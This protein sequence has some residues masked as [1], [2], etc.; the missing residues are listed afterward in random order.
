[1]ARLRLRSWRLLLLWIG[2]GLAFWVGSPSH[3]EGQNGKA[4]RWQVTQK[5][6]IHW[7]V[8]P[9]GKLFYSKGVNF[10]DPGKD[11]PRSQKKH[12]YY[13][14]NFFPSIDEWRRQTTVQLQGWGFNTRGGWSDDSPN[15][16]LPLMVDIELGRNSKFHWFDSFHPTMEERVME[17]AEKLTAPYRHDHR[18]VGYFSDNE[19][20]WW[21]SALF[22][23]YL[24]K[25]WDNY[26]KRVLW[27][28]LYDQYTGEWDRL[29]A[30]WVVPEDVRG[31][32]DLKRADVE[33]KLRPGGSGIRVVD[34]FMFLVAQHYYDL[35]YRSIRKA[36]PEA[37]VLGD[38]L[39]LYYHQDAV[40]AIGD[41]VDVISTNYNV[42]GPDGWVAPYY[43]EGL[44]RLSHKPVIVTE[45]FFAAEENRTGN[46][47]ETARSK[48]P[49][50]GHLMTVQ[51]QEERARGISNTVRRFARFPN[52]VGA[53]WFQYCDEPF[54]GREQDGED[55]NMGL[56]DTSNGAYEEVTA[57]FRLA[58][59]EI[60]S[61]HSEA[62]RV[63][64]RE[65]P[66]FFSPSPAEAAVDG[67]LVVLRASNPPS[68]SDQSLL[69][70]DKDK[71]R[72]P[73]VQAPEPYV[74]F[75]DLHLSW[76][77]EG[78]Y[79]ATI[80]N[81]FVDPGFLAFEGEFPESEAFQIHVAVEADGKIQHQTIYMLPN[82]DANE[83]DG[84]GI[85]PRVV[86]WKS[87]Q[88][89]RNAVPVA[90]AGRV[91]RIHKSLPHMHVEA[92]LPAQSLGYPILKAGMQLSLNI[93]MA[94][95]YREFTMSWPGRAALDQA[96]DPDLMKTVVLKN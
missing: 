11:T 16:D 19:V 15:L 10:I 71:T 48:H 55:Y 93:V 25:D 59:S 86:Q 35:M 68:V 37:L 30:D 8:D 57:V 40:K 26:T 13:W 95:Y 67:S 69:D 9:Q 96:A 84:F 21:N 6:G 24:S 46:R 85:K 41:N 18:L 89:T 38:R 23:W 90:T 49:K 74:P 27:Q 7:L 61:I 65:R 94:N 3:A 31:F 43:F 62:P 4:T 66:G 17:W 92:F 2:L 83:P 82:P 54:G 75:G 87:G 32:E 80:S 70:W 42:D 34:R 64:A 45:F 81:T 22:K 29:L 20:G 79:L 1:M 44:Q 53:H 5:D 14:G 78:L 51:T 63:A 76:G 56:I 28:L 39:P 60:E 58:N 47:N 91:Q 33:L 36:H 73:N 50:P 77:P 12:A 88:P 52:V 72:I